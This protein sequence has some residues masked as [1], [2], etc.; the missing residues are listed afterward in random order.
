MEYYKTL[1]IH[2]EKKGK[3]RQKDK[4]YTVAVALGIPAHLRCLLQPEAG[5]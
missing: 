3:E 5:D 2:R 1:A 4:G